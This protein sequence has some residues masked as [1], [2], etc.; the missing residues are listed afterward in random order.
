M[1]WLPTMHLK[2]GYPKSETPRITNHFQRCSCDFWTTDS[3][4]ILFIFFIMPFLLYSE[5]SSGKGSSSQWGQN[6][7]V[8]YRYHLA[9]LPVRTGQ[10]LWLCLLR[11]IFSNPMASFG[12]S[13]ALCSGC[14]EVLLT[15]HKARI[16]CTCGLPQCRWIYTESTMKQQWMQYSTL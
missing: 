13:P 11:G 2:G 6:A 9:A 12:D 14:S 5:I 4:H 10:C 7:S 15:A 1:A 8:V 16:H 3:H